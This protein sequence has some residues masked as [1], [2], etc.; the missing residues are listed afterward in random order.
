MYI[1]YFEETTEEPVLA[2]SANLTMIGI[3]ETT[4]MADKSIIE[5]IIAD[6]TN[7]S[8]SSVE[9]TLIEMLSSITTRDALLYDELSNVRLIRSGGDR[10]LINVAVAPRDIPHEAYAVTKMNTTI[11]FREEINLGLQ[12]Q[13]TE[14]NTSVIS[15]SQITRVPGELNCVHILAYTKVTPNTGRLQGRHG[16]VVAGNRLLGDCILGKEFKFARSGKG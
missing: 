2:I 1:Y 8:A 15:V 10:A 14:S 6:I 9:A 7:S 3:N 16:R 12:N 5:T 4:F 13:P 11:T